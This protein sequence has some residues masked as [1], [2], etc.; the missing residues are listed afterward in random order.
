ME[1]SSKINNFRIV[2]EVLYRLIFPDEKITK[3]KGVLGNKKK[4]KIE[5]GAKLTKITNL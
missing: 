2:K 1:S 3:Q 5:K 4:T